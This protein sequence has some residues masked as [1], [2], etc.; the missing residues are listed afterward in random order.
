MS[1]MYGD[2]RGGLEKEPILVHG[3]VFRNKEISY[4][5]KA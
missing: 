4:P 2:G 3:S 5:E 1:K